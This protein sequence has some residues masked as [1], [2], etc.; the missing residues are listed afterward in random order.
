MKP[1]EINQTAKKNSTAVA[2]FSFNRP[3]YLA[4]T[5]RSLQANNAPEMDYYLFQDGAVNQYS[6]RTMA[7]EQD[8]NLSV[9]AW[10][11]AALPNKQLIKKS[12]NV[13]IGIIQYEAKA[14]LFDELK[15]DRVMF[16][17]DDMVVSKHYIRLLQTMLR[18]YRDE[19]VVGAVMCHGGVPVIFGE[20]EQKK[21]LP[22]VRPSFDNLWAWA[23]WR[24]RW[25]KIRPTFDRYYQ[26]IKD[27]EYKKRPEGEI[28]E[29]YAREGANITVSSQ[30]AAMHYSFAKNGYGCLNTMVHR[31]SYIG[32]VGEHMYPKKFETL[33]YAIIKRID[34]A[35]DEKRGIFDGYDKGRMIA[36]LRNSKISRTYAP[37]ESLKGVRQ[38]TAVRLSPS[39]PKSTEEGRSPVADLIQR[40]QKI[41]IYSANASPS[42]WLAIDKSALDITRQ[43]DFAG[44]WESNTRQ[45]FLAEDVWNTLTWQQVHEA[46][47]NCFEFLSK[48]GT[49][50]I[51][52]PDGNHPDPL[53]INEIYAT[54][55][56]AGEK[57]RI[58]F[59]YQSLSECLRYVGFRIVLLEYWDERR[60]LHTAEWT[61]ENGPVNRTAK[62][63][64]SPGGFL[65]T[66][67][68]IDAVKT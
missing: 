62:L 16:F 57:Q 2:V 42:G 9:E 27:V 33:G 14:L 32:A 56:R 53:Y 55:K 17:E 47:A 28:L 30:D 45:A 34:F 3:H 38:S 11:M 20:E 18:Q 29:F 39:V 5:L 37:N 15:Y 44:Y 4:Q 52:V 40:A 48:G 50:R 36:A 7:A 51:A 60:V 58:L 49:L 59:D 23:T 31:A 6:G 13:G 24:D 35:E 46:T 1:M 22:M 19:P 67:L 61:F 54:S 26:F 63:G 66:S 12:R 64:K 21:L 25:Q 68:V 10:N 41:S 43:E 8:I 65:N